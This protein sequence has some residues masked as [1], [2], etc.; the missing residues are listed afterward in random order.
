MLRLILKFRTVVRLLSRWETLF[1]S[2]GTVWQE[3]RTIKEMA[4]RTTGLRLMLRLILHLRTVLRILEALP[5]V[6]EG[7]E[8]VWG[9]MVKV[10]RRPPAEKDVGPLVR[11]I[12]SLNDQMAPIIEDF[13]KLR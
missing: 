13:G 9:E 3:S 1:V 5:S 11:A 10:S 6:L 4:S 7:W 12:G 2:L 8:N